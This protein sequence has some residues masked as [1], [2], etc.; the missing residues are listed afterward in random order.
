MLEG[1]GAMKSVTTKI[2][3]LSVGISVAVAQLLT[4]AF[5]VAFKTMV[6]EQVVLVDRTLRE[7]FDRAFDGRWRR[8][9][10]AR[11]G[12]RPRADGADGEAAGDLAKKL[13]RDLR[14]DKEG[15]FWRIPRTGRTSS[16]LAGRG[17]RTA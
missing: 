7:S 14:Y 10:P 9:L 2:I 12:G 8:G 13:L 15:Y 11:Q 4:A 16:C 17:A 1:G 5:A 6:D 3:V